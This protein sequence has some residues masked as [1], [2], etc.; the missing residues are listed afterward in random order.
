MPELP[1]V[2][3][4][5]NILKRTA[6]G[7]R[8]EKVISTE[9]SIVY[10]D[11]I[12]NKQFE[13]EM[14]GRSILEAG[15]FGKVFYVRLD[16]EGRH[17]VMHL[18]MTG[19]VYIKGTNP[20]FYSSSPKKVDTSWPPRFMKFIL[21]LSALPSDPEGVDPPEVVFVDARRLGRIRLCVDPLTEPPI[22]NLGFDPIL[23]MPPV[24]EFI[25]AV[26]KKNCVIKSLLLD[27]S[28]SAGVGNWIADEVLFHSRIHPEQ[29]PNVLG[30]DVLTRLHEKI[31]YVCETA[32]G[33]DADSAQ[34]PEGW[35]FKHRWGKGKDPHIILPNGEKAPIKFLT[36]GSRTSAIVPKVQKLYKVRVF[37]PSIVS[38][39]E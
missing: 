37:H 32:V 5:V 8:V 19:N 21:R 29:K 39:I 7:R 11:G 2:N 1:E 22:S 34:F 4:V 28:F 24:S 3:R 10:C 25:E 26:K 38:C 31:K 9:D 35:L 30:E 36:V 18:G 33:V 14:T 12:D 20:A 17:P 16:G 6:L 23:S 15:R 27:Q 13:E